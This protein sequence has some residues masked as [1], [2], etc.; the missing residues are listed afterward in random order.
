[1]ATGSRALGADMPLDG[2]QVDPHGR[3]HTVPRLDLVEVMR[4][5]LLDRL[6]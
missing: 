6:R 3:S 2:R 5:R 1:M 4:I